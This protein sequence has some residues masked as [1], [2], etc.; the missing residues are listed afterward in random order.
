MIDK[1]TKILG[2][3][4]VTLIITLFIIV[5]MQMNNEKKY[6]E[7]ESELIESAGLYMMK[8]NPVVEKGKKLKITEKMLKEYDLLPNMQVEEDKCS[9]SIE[10]TKKVDEYAYNPYIKCQKYESYKEK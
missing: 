6:K 9:G 10:V 8:V 7:L 2:F 3:F 5:F 4:S 1:K